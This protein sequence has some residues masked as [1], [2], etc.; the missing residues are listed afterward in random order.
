MLEFVI[1]E[2]C[3]T[4]RALNIRSKEEFNVVIDVVKLS[5]ATSLK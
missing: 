2:T 4:I 5:L 3:S 1:S